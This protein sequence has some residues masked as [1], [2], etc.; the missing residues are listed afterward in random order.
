MPLTWGT[1]SQKKFDSEEE[2]EWWSKELGTWVNGQRA[3]RKAFQ[4]PAEDRTESEKKN[5][6]GITERRIELLEGIGLTGTR[7]RRRGMACSRSWRRTR[8]RPGVLR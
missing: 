5:A 3:F 1:Q 7:A 8:S 4:K 6:A 2:P